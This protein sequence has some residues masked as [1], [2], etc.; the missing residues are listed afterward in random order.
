MINKKQLV[1]L[2]DAELD[3]M[4][5]LWSKSDACKVIDIYNGLKE[6][7]PLSKP[8]IHT[9]L[10]RL[11][12][13][14]FVK[15]QTVEAP[16]PYKT[17]FPIVSEAEYRTAES[18]NLVDRLFRG[19]WKNLIAALVDNGKITEADIDEI[20]RMIQEKEAES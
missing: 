6:T 19:N 20:T 18:E 3:I 9:L 4:L 10:E 13:R 11:E 7:H 8:A 12:N 15:S 17:I 1:K 16:T 14:G 5:V 2:P